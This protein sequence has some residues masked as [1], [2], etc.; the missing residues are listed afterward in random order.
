[1]VDFTLV[2]HEPSTKLVL[3]SVNALYNIL[4]KQSPSFDRING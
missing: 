3:S 4:F 2:F 1:M